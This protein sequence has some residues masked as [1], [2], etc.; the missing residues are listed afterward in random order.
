MKKAPCPKLIRNE[1]ANALFDMTP[2]EAQ[3][4]ARL[5]ASLAV[6]T[7]NLARGMREALAEHVERKGGAR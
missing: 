7:G 4:F 1:G 3:Q 6:S 5:A 2:D